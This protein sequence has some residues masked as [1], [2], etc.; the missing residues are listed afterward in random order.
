[1]QVGWDFKEEKCSII[2]IRLHFEGMII[3]IMFIYNE[4]N[5]P[6]RF[7]MFLCDWEYNSLGI[8]HGIYR[9]F[10]VKKAFSLKK[11]SL[12]AISTNMVLV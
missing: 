6:A 8:W 9:K 4:K 3:L 11:V 7:N 12:D 5:I 1:M 10:E 2:V